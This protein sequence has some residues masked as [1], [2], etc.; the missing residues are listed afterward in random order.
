MTMV[1][2]QM[3]VS[4]GSFDMMILQQFCRPLQRNYLT[5]CWKVSQAVLNPGLLK[6]GSAREKIVQETYPG[7]VV[8]DSS[9]EFSLKD[10]LGFKQVVEHYVQGSV[11]PIILRVR[12]SPSI[13]YSEQIMTKGISSMTL[14]SLFPKE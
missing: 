8:F 13:K 2:L 4:C 6:V 14:K 7:K 11:L 5:D 3:N 12:R 1:I 10:A 9:L